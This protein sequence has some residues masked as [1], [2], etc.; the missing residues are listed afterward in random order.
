MEKQYSGI[1]QLGE[2][3]FRYNYSNSCVEYVA[4]IDGSYEVLDSAGLRRENWEN[5]EARDEY[6]S[7][8]S[9]DLDEELRWLLREF[10]V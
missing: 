1:Y 6:L 8:W 2:K 4:Q 5:Q 3:S 9:D 7:S 10:V